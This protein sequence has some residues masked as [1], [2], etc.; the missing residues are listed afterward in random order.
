MHSVASVLG[1]VREFLGLVV[2]EVLQKINHFQCRRR[3]CA[4]ETCLVMFHPSCLRYKACA[5]FGG[6]LWSTQKGTRVKSTERGRV[7]LSWKHWAFG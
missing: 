1:A 4:E 6:D 2:W 7:H 3:L 5:L